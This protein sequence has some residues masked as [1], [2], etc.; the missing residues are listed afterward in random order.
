MVSQISKDNNNSTANE[1]STNPYQSNMDVKSSIEC[2]VKS[3][4]KPKTT[5]DS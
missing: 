3:W 4:Q 5:E 2:L 1:F